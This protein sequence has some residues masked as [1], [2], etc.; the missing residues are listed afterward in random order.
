MTIETAGTTYEPFSNEPI[1]VEANRA[2]VARAPLAGTRRFL[3]LACGTGTV[4]ALLV[5]ASPRAHLNGIDLD[6]VQIRLAGERFRALGYEV[7]DGFAL[8]EERAHGRPV[9]T[10]AAGSALEL[11][12]P[13]ASFD[14]VTIANAIHLMPDRGRFL[15]GVARVLRPGGLFGFNS[16]FYAGSMPKG[17]DRIYLDWLRLAVEWIDERNR[18]LAAAGRPPITRT[19]GTSRGAFKARWLTAAEWSGLLDAAGLT[20]QAPFERTIALDE[21]CLALVGAYG[22]MAEV[23]LNGYPVEAA[24]EALQAAAGPAMAL[25]SATTVPRNY[26]ELWGVK[27]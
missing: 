2:F 1:Y 11:P 19:R 26:L 15:A 8:T 21:R 3:D 16:A 13:D 27:R 12:F 20:P 17:T 6:P 10:F 24:S 25:S 9:L 4:S 23:L 5:A 18:A 14:C 7:R 22:G